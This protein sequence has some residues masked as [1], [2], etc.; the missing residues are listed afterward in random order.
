MFALFLRVS[1]RELLATP[2]RTLL[3]VSGVAIGV[4]MMTAI[5]VVNRGILRHFERSVSA[6]SGYADLQVVTPGGEYRL[7]PAIAFSVGEIAGVHAAIPVID[8]SLPLADGSDRIR[9]FGVD[10]T[11]PRVPASYGVTLAGSQDPLDLLVD[12]D[13]VLALPSSAT[14]RAQPVGSTFEVSTSV[15]TRR[16]RVAAHLAEAPTLSAVPETFV[17]VDIGRAQE[18]LGIGELTDRID[19][20]LE[21]AHDSGVLATQIRM[22]LAGAFDVVTPVGR[23][24]YFENAVYAYQRT[25]EGFSL[26]ALLAAVFIAY[27]AVSTSVAAR[28]KRL[29]TLQS[30]GA[31]KRDVLGML[32]L[33]SLL[34]GLFASILGALLGVPLAH[35]LFSLVATMMG[36]IFLYDVRAGDFAVDF[37]QAVS[38]IAVGVGATL[39]ASWYPALRASRLEPLVVL[40]RGASAT[41]DDH[42]QGTRF[43]LTSAALMSAIVVIATAIEVNARSILAGNVASVCWF[44]AFILFSVPAITWLSGWLATRLEQT[45]GVVGRTAAENLRRSAGRNAVAVSALAM[46]VATTVTLGGILFSFQESLSAYIQGF[47]HADFVISSAHNRGGWLEEPISAEFVTRA[48]SVPGVEVVETGRFEPG[49]LFRGERVCIMAASDGFL[50]RD[51]YEP[52]FRSRNID[53]AMDAVRQDSAVLVSESLSRLTGVKDGDVLVLDTPVGTQEFAVVGTVVDYASDRGTIVMSQRLFSRLW[54]DDRVTRIYVMVAPGASLSAVQ[55]ALVTMLGEVHDIK[56]MKLADLVS[57][58]RRFLDRAFGAARVLEL[59]IVIV[60]LAGILEALI[61]RTYDRRREFALLRVAGA[62]GGQI[63]S[64]ILVEA[65]IMIMC[66]LALGLFGGTV[67][68]WMWVNYHFSYLLGWLLDFHFPWLIAGRAM[69]LAGTVATAAAYWPAR[70]TA[71]RPLIEALRYE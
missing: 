42:P 41:S 63:V 5:T 12:S 19:V 33:E 24:A 31:R 25:I 71:R 11:D 29:A 8:T 62:T 6:L 38:A 60:T 18:L 67:S 58:H 51:R 68:A 1:L 53:S 20:M 44:I 47:M 14:G 70:A 13:A 45:V 30:M 9:V 61:S 10:F 4:A 37:D 3:I 7:D 21:P 57:Y 59:L 35:R 34:L 56:V 26:L 17:V 66:G 50:T 39:V 64:V 52:W 49:Q 65:G 36:T 40:N 48:R 16:L 2:I 54:R 55:Q 28:T 15:G 23:G 22:K 46:S 27:S 69:V 43:F 32:T